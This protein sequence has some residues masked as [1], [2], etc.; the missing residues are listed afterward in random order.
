MVGRVGQL[1]KVA[2]DGS[3]GL[4]LVGRQG[5]T[6]GSPD[7]SPVGNGGAGGVGGDGGSDGALGGAGGAGGFGDVSESS[8]AVESGNAAGTGGEGGAGGLG[9][10]S[11]DTPGTG[12]EGGAG[13]TAAPPAAATAATAPPVS[14]KPAP[15]AHLARPDSDPQHQRG[16]RPRGNPGPR[17]RRQVGYWATKAYPR[18]LKS[19]ARKRTRSLV[20][21]E[22]A[23]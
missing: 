16:P 22:G 11:G 9:E 10:N 19:S 8:A 5:L 7:T 1:A 13:G 12:G 21:H 2:V 20:D 6:G 17:C 15:R 18:D 4:A 3:T 14:A 23:C